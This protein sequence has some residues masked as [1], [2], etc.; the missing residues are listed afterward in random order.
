PHSWR[1][2]PRPPLDHATALQHERQRTCEDA[3][4]R[5]RGHT[6]SRR[7]ARPILSSR[8]FGMVRREGRIH[9]LGRCHIGGAAYFGWA[10]PPKVGGT[11]HRHGQVHR[12]TISVITTSKQ[13]L[14]PLR[15][16]A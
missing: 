9:A 15:V 4:V 7:S 3:A 11:A 8:G 14:L 16:Y 13:L 5:L 1:R 10:L 12:H 2:P 6:W